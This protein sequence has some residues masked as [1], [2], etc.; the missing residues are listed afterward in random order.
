MNADNNFTEILEELTPPVRAKAVEIANSML[1][2]V[3]YDAER[4]VDIG[5][6]QALRWARENEIEIK[7]DSGEDDESGE[8]GSTAAADPESIDHVHVLS[9]GD[10]WAVIRENAGK[11]PSRFEDKGEALEAAKAKVSD[12]P[13]VVL[14]H[15]ERGRIEQILN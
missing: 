4:A 5:K 12:S 3:N 14:V 9:R 7:V 11:K 10:D 13:A 15:D 1:E 8:D 6:R 2:M